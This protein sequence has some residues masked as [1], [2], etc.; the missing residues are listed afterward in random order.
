MF[1][2]K[3]KKSFEGS[4]KNHKPKAVRVSSRDLIRESAIEPGNLL[5]LVIEPAVSGLRLKD[6]TRDNLTWV[7]EKLLEHGGILFR[8]F[9]LDSDAAFGDY[10]ESLP[11]NRMAYVEASTPRQV[12]GDKVYTSTVYPE[13][14]TIA[15][16]NECTSSMTFPKKV[17]F[18]CLEE[19]E[20]GGETPIASS[21]GVLKRIDP[22]VLEKFE[23][24]GWMLIRNFGDGLG[25]PWRGAYGISDPAEME[26]YCRKADIEIRWSDPAHDHLWTRQVRAAT[27][28]HPVSGEKSWFNHMAFWHP[29]NLCPNVLEEMVKQLGY[30]GLPYHTFYGD[31]SPIPDEVARHV[32]RAY[33]AE[34]VKFRWR[35]GDLLWVDNMLASHG[36]ESFRGPRK[37]RVAMGDTMTRE[38]FK[39]LVTA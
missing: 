17:W 32:A 36:R 9:E 4:F 34:K 1:A 29:A 2:G 5:P 16:H 18:F 39:P 35:K 6:W 11:Y 21:T 25:L 22:E 8:G 20:E 30:D 26:A 27:M 7:E 28:T 38:P 10:I 19:P 14:E 33:E 13:D 31:G 15:L 24:L 37:I 12:V 3:T 23:R